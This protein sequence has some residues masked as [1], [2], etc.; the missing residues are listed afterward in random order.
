MLDDIVRRLEAGETG[1]PLDR[2]I[3]SWQGWLRVPPSQSGRKHGH[4]MHPD[5]VL[6][7][8][9]VYDGLHGTSI[10]RDVPNYTTLIDVALDLVTAVCGRD[11]WFAI[12]RQNRDAFRFWASCAPDASPA[13][14]GYDAPVTNSS[15]AMTAAGALCLAA[16]K[17]ARYNERRMGPSA[18]PA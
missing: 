17:Q 3:A 10:H 12:E 13:G 9:P 5:D 6:N 18:S 2:A 4:W 16:C 14:L 15:W 1:K 7:G 11:P 8:K